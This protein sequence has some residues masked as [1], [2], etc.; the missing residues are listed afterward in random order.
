MM[1]RNSLNNRGFTLIELLVVIAIIAILISLLLPA[2]GTARRIAQQVVCSSTMRGLAQAQVAYTLENDDF[3][4]GL[5][6][7]GLLAQFS[8]RGPGGT[9]RAGD[10]LRGLTT[11][12]TPT[13]TWDWISPLVGESAGLSADRA[14]RTA[15]IFSKLGSPAAGAQNDELYDYNGLGSERASWEK[16]FFEYG[17]QQVSYL[18][19]GGFVWYRDR[20]HAQRWAPS[21]SRIGGTP[22]GGAIPWNAQDRAQQVRSPFDVPLQHNLKISSPGIRVPSDKVMFANGTR[23]HFRGVLDFDVSTA[24]GL[25]SSFVSSGPAFQSSTAYGRTH[26]HSPDQE[27]VDFSFM[28]PGRQINVAYWDGSVRSMSSS[29]AWSNPAP[30]YPSGSEYTGGDATPEVRE[31]FRP[32]DKLP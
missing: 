10:S 31:K 15:Q 14:V 26:R 12:T 9:V 3:Y 23:Y 11:P 5:N 22:R 20:Q 8:F 2:L 27:N 21:A 17:F 13:T 28:H 4:S 6:T 30:W 19:P 29:E 16:A 32:G 25:Y 18:M 1:R 7:T 24:P